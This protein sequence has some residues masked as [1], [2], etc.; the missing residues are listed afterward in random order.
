MA[1]PTLQI[2][3]VRVGGVLGRGATS[4]VYA[5]E[6][7]ATGERVAIKLHLQTDSSFTQGAARIRREAATLSTMR[8]PGLARIHGL[9]TTGDLTYLIME[10]LEGGSLR[11]R[12][13]RGPLSEGQV[14]SMAGVLA[15]ALVEVHR[16]GIVH[17]D[18]KPEN[19]LFD[20]ANNPKLIDFGFAMPLA[21]QGDGELAGT[22]LYAAPEQTGVLKRPVDGR[23]DLY[24]LG[25]VLF[26]CCSGHPPFESSDAAQIAH[27][28]LT[29][30]APELSTVVP[31]IAPALSEIVARLLEKDP[32]ARYQSAS[33]LLSD[34]RRL[35]L[36][37]PDQSLTLSTRAT[38]PSSERFCV[39][40][41]GPLE[42]LL[43]AWRHVS[44]PSNEGARRTHLSGA[45]GSGKTC[46]AEVAVE[47][48]QGSAS[49]VKDRAL[50]GAARYSTV[51][52]LL[53]QWGGLL[54]EFPAPTREQ[55]RST[56]LTAR[57][58]IAAVL[59]GFC[60]AF[61][62]SVGLTAT[63]AP[64]ELSQLE[65]ETVLQLALATLAQAGT[66]G[67]IWVDDAHL[68]DP[69]SLSVID[70]LI[71]DPLVRIWVLLSGANRLN[72]ER[73]GHDRVVELAPLPQQAIGTLLGRQLGGQLEPKV[74]EIVAQ[75]SR[76]NPLLANAYAHALVEQG[77]LELFWGQ[78]RMVRAD[79]DAL[80]LADSAAGIVLSRLQALAPATRAV[81]EAAAVLGARF[82]L[83]VLVAVAQTPATMAA[84]SEA[85]EH[86]VIEPVGPSLWQFSQAI[87]L[88]KI[89]G[90]LAPARASQLHAQAFAALRQQSASGE[91]QLLAMA[92]HAALADDGLSPHE[93]YAVCLAAGRSALARHAL[94]DANRLLLAAERSAE[95]APDQR[96][97]LFEAL[98]EVAARQG[99]VEAATGY[100][101]TALGSA[102]T[103]LARGRIRE[104][105]VRAHLAH[106][107]F[108]PVRTEV[109]AALPGLVV[110]LGARKPQPN[111]THTPGAQGSKQRHR[112]A[113]DGPRAECFEGF[114]VLAQ[115]CRHSMAIGYMFNEEMVTLQSLLRGRMYAERLGPSPELSRAMS[116]YGFFLAILRMPERAQKANEAA[117]VLART[118]ND[119]QSSANAFYF[120]AMSA[121]MVGDAVAAEQYADRSFVELGKWLDLSDF[122]N[123]C[124]DL[125]WSLV[126]RGYA[127]EAL[128]WYERTEVRVAKE[129]V[130]IAGTDLHPWT[131]CLAAIHARLGND[132][133]AESSLQ[134]A[135]RLAEAV[136]TAFQ[137][138]NFSAYA[139][140]YCLER[141]EEGE[142]L[143]RC[144]ARW[145][146]LK[147]SPARVALHLRSYYVAIAYV[148]LRQLSRASTTEKARAR[149]T[150]LA[151]LKELKATANVPILRC[152]LRVLEGALAL[153][154]G[155]LVKARS[156]LEAAEH[157]AS[158]CD[159][160]WALYEVALWRARVARALGNE[161]LATREA[162][163]AAGIARE[164][165]WARRQ[166]A[167]TVEFALAPALSSHA[168]LASAT[169]G[170]SALVPQRQ[171]EAL[172]SVSVAS[173]G[174]LDRE[175]Q[176]RKVLD[177]LVA[178]FGSDRAF[179]FLP[180][181]AGR[182]EATAGRDDQGNDITAEKTY[183]RTVAEKVY[184]ANSALILSGTEEGEILGAASVV[185]HGLRSIMAAPIVLGGERMGVVYT[186][187][188]VARGLFS[189]QAAMRKCWRRSPIMSRL[190]SRWPAPPRSRKS[191]ARSRRTW[192]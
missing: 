105:I 132:A 168:D 62:T 71:E 172:L 186:D 79:V 68:I 42:E 135:F 72:G 158:T 54:A 92:N 140:T 69:G 146:S 74:L 157:D 145:A 153:I 63:G 138:A 35:S 176:A 101:H 125:V 96:V 14:V 117:L 81:L 192:P 34:L 151:S 169:M 85:A 83:E 4:V 12:L 55:L 28:H 178:V 19:I 120:R 2:P 1:H 119:P 29:R 99:R 86:S 180:N 179:M 50:P 124:G 98:G 127:R 110:G 9:G 160:A 77:F 89:L 61:A 175:E 122:M 118:I 149:H 95:S 103:G 17:R 148:R 93:R 107:D 141:D 25:V 57:G 23:S 163:V 13:Q 51:R 5:G 173:A 87:V 48:C 88:E 166:S 115:L 27:L 126:Y 139:V 112:A 3:G 76:G 45:T 18:I 104:R 171:L 191:A 52:N 56:L 26:E 30:R 154:D 189:S 108:A 133:L 80:Q 109:A 46:L 15:A 75:R 7:E 182:L 100:L 102:Q 53:S 67:V 40:R 24:S 32:D 33:G 161:R 181:A 43:E 167:A 70:R 187:T 152:H 137:W 20:L 190:A 111:P 159:S 150:L 73:S 59:T 113:R 11:E 128:T 31:S 177:E 90:D 165:G 82:E 16:R 114:R 143:E 188:R 183:S 129:R 8:H 164:G 37:T 185:A 136:H 39:G 170:L 121:S 78:W 116:V 156:S 130:G 66:P 10:A 174:S 60:P 91:E 123:G 21:D 44:K 65:F 22:L 155:D 134:R 94:D 162:Q 64:P 58:D 142:W 38:P 147:L 84:V 49:V 36:L 6:S 144:F 106:W 184:S 97:T 47:H 131:H 41:E